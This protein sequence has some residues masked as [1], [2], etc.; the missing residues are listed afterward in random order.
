M[1]LHTRFLQDGL[2]ALGQPDGLIYGYPYRFRRSTQREWRILSRVR[3]R[4]R[5]L[6]FRGSIELITHRC[7]YSAD[8]LSD[9]RALGTHCLTN[10]PR[11]FVFCIRR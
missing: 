2:G 3:S 5:P 7:A 9:K 10:R 1:L 8:P 11:W 6:R 4:H